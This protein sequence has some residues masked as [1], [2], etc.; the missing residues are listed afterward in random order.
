MD[1]NHIHDHVLQV[2]L[3]S[4][5]L[6]GSSSAM[7]VKCFMFSQEGQ[8]ALSALRRSVIIHRPNS[9][10]GDSI[11]HGSITFLKHL[12]EGFSP[13]NMLVGKS[14]EASSAV[15]SAVF[16]SPLMGSCKSA[17]ISSTVSQVSRF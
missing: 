10:T 16:P 4:K 6:E 1:F 11:L 14:T 2:M 12:G 7:R 15:V 9:V 13:T 17:Q 5:D 8:D 3:T